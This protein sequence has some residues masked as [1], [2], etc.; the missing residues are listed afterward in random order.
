MRNSLGRAARKERDGSDGSDNKVDG[1]ETV[2]NS[3]GRA[4]L[5]KSEMEATTRW[6]EGKPWEIDTLN[7]FTGKVLHT[8]AFTQRSL[9][10]E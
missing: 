8:E 1:G 5:G 6:T 7:Y 10:T 3:L 2:G 9:Y 4:P